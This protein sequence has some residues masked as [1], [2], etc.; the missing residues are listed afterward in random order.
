MQN[1]RKILAQLN[2]DA[3]FFDGL[4]EA[5]IGIGSQYPHLP[6]AVYSKIMIIQELE[7]SMTP[8]DADEWYGHN[9]ACLHGGKHTPI[10]MC[11]ECVL[12]SSD[13]VKDDWESEVR[14]D[15]KD[16]GWVQIQ[17]NLN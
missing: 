6:V 13:L 16:N 14:K 10:I 2:E 3:I 9:I 4:D 7:T 15:R 12:M 1:I 8:E 17:V 11:E 5:I